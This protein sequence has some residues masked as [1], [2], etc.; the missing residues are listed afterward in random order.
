MSEVGE[1][2][3]DG[4]GDEVEVSRRTSG[5]LIDAKYL[6]ANRVPDMVKIEVLV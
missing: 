2:A 1:G 5:R 6:R 3:Y 4:C